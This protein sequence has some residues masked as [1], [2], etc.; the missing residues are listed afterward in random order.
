MMTTWFQSQRRR[1]AVSIAL[2]IALSFVFWGAALRPEEG[3]ILYGF[4]LER[5]F[6]PFGDFMYEAFRQGR[7]PLWNPFVF[8]GF[9][10][11]A[12]PQLSTFYPL[13]WPMQWL[14]LEVV[15]PLQYALHYALAAVGGYVLIRQLG[16]KTAGALLTGVT[17]AFMLTMTVRIYVGHMPH[18]MTL[19]WMPWILAA[20]DWAIRRRSWAATLVAALP[21]GLAFLVGYIPFL[22]YVVAGL[23]LYMLWLAFVAW[24][25]NGVRAGVHVVVQ[26]MALGIFAFALAAVQL[27]PSVEFTLLSNRAADRYNFANSFPIEFNHL[28]TVVMPDIFGAP[29]GQTAWWLTL[30]DAVYWEWALYVGVLPLIFFLLAWPV[31]R[32]AWRF[33]VVFGILGVVAGLGDAGA[34]H[35]VLYDY[36]PGANGF[37]FVGRS[38]YFWSL[39]AAVLLGLMFDAWFDVSAEIHARRA[40]KLRTFL[41]IFVS[42]MLVLIVAAVLWQ[43]AQE[44][45]AQIGVL[46]GVTSQFVRLLL[47]ATAS[48][49][50]LI[51]GYGR[52]R[53]ALVA[54]ALALMLVDLWGVGNKF[55]TDQRDETELA[56]QTADVGLP[57]NRLDYRVW[58]RALPEN[59]GYYHGFYH[60]YGY[61]GFSAEASEVFNDLAARDARI[62]RLLSARYLIYGPDWTDPPTAPGWEKIGEPAGGVFWERQ[63]AGPR[64]FVVHDVIGVADADEALAVM[65][66]PQL[67]FTQTAVV[68]RVPDTGCGVE[69]AE[70]TASSASIVSY[71]PEQV[72]IAVDAAARGWLVLNDLDYPGWEVTV[73]GEPD[74][75]QPTDYALRGVCVPAGQSEV[76]FTFRP[77]ILTVGATLSL[78]AGAIWIAALLRLWQQRR[79]VHASSLLD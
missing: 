73:N 32:K 34:L 70:S 63:D 62:A 24:R 51:W 19:A 55:I 74:V 38:V 26:W 60:V 11:Y 42:V 52:P 48:L 1:D 59:D 4:D 46:S 72:V 77:M 10:Q 33:W 68:E 27:L 79:R 30:P 66:Q 8:L 9:P 15:L 47:L 65:A 36:V 17:L 58:S 7:L 57:P 37:R 71:E 56:W 20:A 29:V 35:R 18:I 49:A 41:L 64:A 39:S 69:S 44:D 21:L 43:G 54:L 16:G 28:L 12:E 13:T 14:P 3:R 50:L 53:W 23:S 45:P 40:A 6:H 2:L 22:L 61:D 67:D 25:Q 78:V 31:G 5:L 76:V 75:I